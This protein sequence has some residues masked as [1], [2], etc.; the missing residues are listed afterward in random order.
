MYLYIHTHIHEYIYTCTHLTNIRLQVSMSRME[1]LIS[2]PCPLLPWWHYLQNTSTVCSLLYH[3]HCYNLFEASI[4]YYLYYCI[5]FLIGSPNLCCAPVRCIFKPVARVIFSKCTSDNVTPLF[6]TVKRLPISFIKK[7]S[8]M[9]VFQACPML[10]TSPI[11]SL[12]LSPVSLLLGNLTLAIYPLWFFLKTAFALVF[13]SPQKLIPPE[14]CMAFPFNVFSV[15]FSVRCCLSTF[16]K[17]VSHHPLYF[18]FPFPV[19][20][21]L[22]PL[23]TRSRY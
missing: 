21:L 13:P 11:T 12:T 22:L 23:I 15:T 1:L 3:L 8:F 7:T 17:I 14:T 19:L 4:T 10:T 2:T 18:L 20:L 5:K 16:L 9:A 6:K